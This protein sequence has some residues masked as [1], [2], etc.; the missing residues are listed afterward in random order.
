MT[1]LTLILALWVWPNSTE[2]SNNLIFL[3]NLNPQKYALHGPSPLKYPLWDTYLKGSVH[4]FVFSM[5]K[6]FTCM[7]FCAPWA[8]N[9]CRGWKRRWTPTNCSC[10]WL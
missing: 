10:R 7:H 9:A 6:C 8:C 5:Q 2:S 3:T 4:L 1:D